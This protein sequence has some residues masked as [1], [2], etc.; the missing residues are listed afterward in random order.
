MH[1]IRH[2]LNVS[3]LKCLFKHGQS[4]YQVGV[5]IRA[6]TMGTHCSFLKC[7]ANTPRLSASEVGKCQRIGGFCTEALKNVP[8]SMP[9]FAALLPLLSPSHLRALHKH[10]L[11]SLFCLPPS[12][13]T[14]KPMFLKKFCWYRNVSQALITY[15]KASS[16]V[17]KLRHAPGHSYQTMANAIP[18]SSHVAPPQTQYYQNVKMSDALCKLCVHTSGRSQ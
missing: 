11:S 16:T 2:L 17:N 10:I 4:H 7:P 1:A 13:L 9:H 12:L 15:R 5:S 18:Y 3:V 6:N 8:H 14:K